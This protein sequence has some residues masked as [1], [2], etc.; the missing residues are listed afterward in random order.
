MRRRDHDLQQTGSTA[1]LQP[2]PAP[3]ERL[4]TVG[5]EHDV[6]GFE[7]AGEVLD[8]AEIVQANRPA[9]VRFRAERLR[10]VTL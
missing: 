8:G 2:R 10:R 3:Y 1:G 4:A 9:S 5:Q 7:V 6:A